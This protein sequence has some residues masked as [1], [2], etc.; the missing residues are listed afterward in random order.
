MRSLF[1]LLLS[2][3]LPLFRLLTV[4]SL[5]SVRVAFQPCDQ[6]AFHHHF[7]PTDTQGWKIRVVQKVVRTCLG[8]LQRFG[9]LLGI[10]HIGHGLKGFSGHKILLSGIKK[11]AT[12][13]VTAFMSKLLFCVFIQKAAVL[14]GHIIL[15]RTGDLFNMLA[16]CARCLEAN[17]SGNLFE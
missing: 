9:K 17:S 5:L 3:K 14:T 16:D 10:H 7:T 1:L 12:F 4:F 2:A 6:F 8:Y 13:F 15:I 11:A